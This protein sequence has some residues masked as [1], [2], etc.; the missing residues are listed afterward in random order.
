MLDPILGIAWFSSI[1]D[2][3]DQCFDHASYRKKVMKWK[4]GKIPRENQKIY[5]AQVKNQLHLDK[6]R[7]K[8]ICGILI[9]SYQLL[10]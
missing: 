7:G 10:G 8:M 4:K 2:F 6:Y 1:S 9:F 3:I 5:R